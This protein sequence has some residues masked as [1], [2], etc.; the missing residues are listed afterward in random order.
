LDNLTGHV[1]IVDDDPGV[2]DS[3]QFLLEVAGHAVAVYAS[4]AKFLA[5]D[6][7]RPACLIV[8]QHMPGMTGLELTERLR[9]EG[10]D[11]PVMLITGSP[12]PAIIV[13]AAQ[14][15]IEKVLEK[16]PTE[17]E[18]LGFVAAHR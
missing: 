13:R 3:L 2:L 15:G 7:V 10:I 17:D 18:L 9:N 5:A 11:V 14:L 8:D 1:A 12:S 16:P 6:G 4:A